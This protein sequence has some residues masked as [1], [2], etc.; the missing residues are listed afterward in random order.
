M[1]AITKITGVV[2]LFIAITISSFAQRTITGVVYNNGEPAGGILVEAHKS[3]DSFYTSFDGKYEIKI[4]EKTKFIR[5]TFLDESK[6]VDVDET[7]PDVL[8]FSWDGG[9]LPSEDDEVGVILKDINALQKDRDMDFLNNYSLYREF[10]KQ[11]DYKSALPHWRILYKTYPKSTD[12]I[13]KDG[14]KI[15]ED[16]MNVA[17]DVKTKLNYLDT[18]M[19]I[20]DKRMKYM[21]NVGEYMG[22]KA[23]KYL[24]TIITLDISRDIYIKDLKTGYGFAEKSIEKSDVN[25]EPAV[26]V[27]FM[28][29]TK[30]LYSM[31]E[32]KKAVI[33]DNYE[34]TMNILDQQLENKDQMDKAN[35]AIPLIESIIESSGALDCAGLVEFYTPK[36]KESPKN[37]ALIKKILRMFK[38]EN[39]ENEFSMMLSEKLFQLEPSPEAAYN[40]A[41]SFLKKEDYT[42]AFEYYAKAYN[43]ETDPKTKATYYYEAAGLSLQQGKLQNARDF[44]NMAIKQNGE[45]CEAYMLLG[46][47]Y[48]QASKT[49]SDDEFERSKVFWLAVDYFNK[50]ANIAKCKDDAKNKVSFYSN[51]FPNTEEIFFHSLTIGSNHYLGG[52]INETTKIRAKQ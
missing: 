52:W 26:L 10:Y 35:T 47:V 45:Y 42:K 27:L 31:N 25:V 32:F 5:F 30:I 11:E 40:M 23:A 13:Y 2:I 43:T 22:R 8:N 33:F 34:K 41:R 51:Y 48:A 19:I 24:E 6:K 15:Y 28:Q 36:Y 12:Q 14:L 49:Y 20:Y 37:V 50:A 4:S 44:A 39:C 17:L 21:D 16:K 9:K 18:M 1:K 46:E 38:R 29:C 3:N 7:T